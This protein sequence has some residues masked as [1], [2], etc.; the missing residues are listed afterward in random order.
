MKT[1]RKNLCVFL[2]LVCLPSIALGQQRSWQL[3]MDNDGN[4]AKSMKA[5]T[6][7][8]FLAQRMGPLAESQLDCIFYCTNATFGLATRKSAA[9]QM[10]DYSRSGQEGYDIAKLVAAGVDPLQ[11]TVEFGKKNGIRVFNSIRMN[12]IHDQNYRNAYAKPMF[13]HNKWKQ[14]HQDWLMST[15][16]KRSRTGAWS[17]VNY[18][19]PEVQDKLVAFAEESI[20]QYDLDGISLDFFRHPVFFRSTFDGKKCSD[21]DRAAMTSVIQRIH[22]MVAAESDRRGRKLQLAIRVPDSIE[23]CHDIGL[24]LEQWL[25]NEWIDL[26]VVSGYFRLNE[27][28]YSATLGEK[29]NVTVLASLDESRVKDEQAKAARKTVESCLG[30]A[31]AVRSAGLDGVVTFNL[32]DPDSPVFRQLGDPALWPNLPKDFYASGRGVSRA[33]GGNLPYAAYRKSETLNPAN[34]ISIKP[35]KTASVDIALSPLSNLNRKLWLQFDR[36]ISP[37]EIDVTVSSERV[38]MQ[39]SE[40]NWAMSSEDLED[41]VRTSLRIAVTLREHS[42]PVRWLDAMIRDTTG[43]KR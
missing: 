11:V 2:A 26:L 10:R 38:E 12:D 31:A 29:Y 15:Q 37:N 14:A 22:K 21:A 18:A 16:T 23:Y 41:E 9:W 7:D 36:A 19:I 32:F 17:A 35:G 8:E 34:P 5:M 1:V 39:A 28:K 42:K 30:R 13:L 6:S 40:N 4:E 33:S 27:W 20:T 3:V 25:T 24:D 43:K